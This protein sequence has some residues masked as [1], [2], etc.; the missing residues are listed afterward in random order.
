MVSFVLGLA[1]DAS[2]DR[3]EDGV[4]SR[5]GFVDRQPWGLHADSAALRDAEGGYGARSLRP[6]PRRDVGWR[7]PEAARGSGCNGRSAR[8]TKARTL[9]V[10]GQAHLRFHRHLGPEQMPGTKAGHVQL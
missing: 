1:A 9:P 10:P 8:Q 7:T 4:K 6:R 2:K 3:L 5:T